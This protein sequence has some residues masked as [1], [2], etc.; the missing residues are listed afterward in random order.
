MSIDNKPVGRQPLIAIL[1]LYH[2]YAQ[3]ARGQFEKALYPLMSLSLLG[4]YVSQNHKQTWHLLQRSLAEA[5]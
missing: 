4:I 5:R 1:S 2:C 3:L